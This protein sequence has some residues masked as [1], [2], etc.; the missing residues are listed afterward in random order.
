MSHQYTTSVYTRS[1]TKPSKIITHE[2]SLTSGDLTKILEAVGTKQIDQFLTLQKETET[3]HK[4]QMD[5]LKA[6]NQQQL[7]DMQNVFKEQL[8]VSAAIPKKGISEPPSFSGTQNEDFSSWLKKFQAVAK[9]NQWSDETCAPPPPPPPLCSILALKILPLL[10]FKV[11]I[12]MFKI[13]FKLPFR[14]WNNDLMMLISKPPFA[15][16]FTA[17]NEGLLNQ[18][19]IIR[20]L[21]KSHFYVLISQT[22]TINYFYFL[23]D[24]NLIF[25]WT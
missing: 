24:C 14:L 22:N 4:T 7:T 19:L 9:M 17:E 10:I 3:F 13:I 15:W 12:W 16:I 11:W 8:Q 25:S 2:M 18:F 20:M 6:V 23:T 1:Q 5:D 21:S